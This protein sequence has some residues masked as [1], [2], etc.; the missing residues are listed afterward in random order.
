[1][2][3]PAEESLGR[4]TARG[5]G[6]AYGS[7]AGGRLLVLLSTAILARLL[8]PEEFGLVALALTFTALLDMLRDVGLAEALIIV[9]EEEVEELAHTAFTAMA[10]VG[11][12][13]AAG[14]AAL[15]PLAAAF[16][17]EPQLTPM[18]AVL[19]LTFL[20]R[21]LGSTHYALAQ[22]RMDF[23]ARTAGEVADV[24]VRGGAGIGLA[25]AG[26]GAWSLILGY[27]LGTLAMTLTLWAS[28][29]WR[30]R[31]AIDRAHLRRLLGFGTALTGV[32]VAG[33]LLGT[34]DQLVIGRVL[35]AAALGLYSVAARLP[36][37][38]IVNLSMVAGQVLFPAFASLDGPALARAFLRAMH[39]MA[40]L[41]L[42]LAALLG[43]LAEPAIRV[44]FGDQWLDAVPV[45]Q[46]FVL[47]ALV[48]PITLVCGTVL[49]ARGKAGLLL[50]VAVFQVA[51]VIPAVLLTVDHGIT[52]VAAGHAGAA[53]IVLLLQLGLAMRQLD[54][55]VPAVLRALVG[56]VTTAA[57]VGL[58]A[59]AADAVVDPPLAALAL[60][61][62]A[63]AAAGA[64]V[65]RLVDGAAVRELLGVVLPRLRGSSTPVSAP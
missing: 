40:L 18:M 49:K 14:T 31:P 3:Q 39:H 32:S 19:S 8:T 53:A 47:Y 28:V 25:L 59:Y 17:D 15:G 7:Y 36:E 56:P 58:A 48:S 63:G 6:W 62:L 4:R 12:L 41:A 16:Y 23:R 64:V 34:V 11:L 1:M 54:V 2:S 65:L 29:H 42:P 26:A 13:L 33:A 27:V 50:R 5:M 46:V 35:G 10:G 21:A 20:F 55:S 45:M 37:L 9:P 44:A 61:G 57:A 60:G 22:K 38:A 52:A 30:P 24:V 43:V 51:I